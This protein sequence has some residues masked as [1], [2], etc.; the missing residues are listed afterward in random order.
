MS[1]YVVTNLDGEQ[2]LISTLR[3]AYTVTRYHCTHWRQVMH[4]GVCELNIFGSDNELWTARRQA[5]IW[6][7]AYILLI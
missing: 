3:Y 1:L 4:I 6:T 5:I 2:T 7:N